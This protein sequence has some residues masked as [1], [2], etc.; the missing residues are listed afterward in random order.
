MG[1]RCR[2]A[3]RAPGFPEVSGGFRSAKMHAAFQGACGG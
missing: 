2:A 1:S 3:E